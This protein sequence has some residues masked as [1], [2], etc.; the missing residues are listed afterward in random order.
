MTLE[1]IN[2]ILAGTFADPA[3]RE[4]WEEKRAELLRKMQN[5]EEN[6]RYF[7]EM[8]RYDR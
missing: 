8:R 2:E 6:N 5:N 4:Y 7:S 1:Q 3:D